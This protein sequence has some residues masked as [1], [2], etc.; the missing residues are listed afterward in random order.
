MTV[1]IRSCGTFSH[2]LICHSFIFFGD[3]AK[4]FAYFLSLLFGFFL[5]G[6][7]RVAHILE[8]SL[9]PDAYC[10]LFS[11]SAATCF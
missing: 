1:S 6:L 5:L 8:T 3:V 7:E 10:A 11:R 4:S 9:L 2:L